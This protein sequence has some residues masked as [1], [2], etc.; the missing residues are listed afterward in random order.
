MRNIHKRDGEFSAALGP[1]H[2]YE[3]D[4]VTAQGVEP[5]VAADVVKERMDA[6]Y[7]LENPLRGR[8]AFVG[9]G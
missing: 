3:T 7:G 6:S 9:A 1:G 2:V 5:A 4:L 8:F